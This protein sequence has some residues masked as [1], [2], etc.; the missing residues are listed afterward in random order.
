VLI[1]RSNTP[2][3]TLFEAKSA[4]AAL[5][6][7]AT[8]CEK[9]GDGERSRVRMA[10]WLRRKA[11]ASFTPTDRSHLQFSRR[12][13]GFTYDLVD[14]QLYR[15][16]AGCSRSHNSEIGAF[17]RADWL[18]L[19]FGKSACARSKSWR[20]V[21]RN[22]PSPKVRQIPDYNS[23]WN[24]DSQ[25]M[26]LPPLLPLPTSTGQGHAGI[27]DQGSSRRRLP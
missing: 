7:A 25:D 18:E 1:R 21:D 11:A 8:H 27:V 15:R 5:C 16:K 4:L 2:L 10:Q 23:K 3:S 26:G 17:H 19:L 14:A 22:A 20:N 6:G 13:F 9:Q 12:A 24:I